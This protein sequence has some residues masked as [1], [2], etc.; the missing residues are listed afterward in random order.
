MLCSERSSSLEN[1][2]ERFSFALMSISRYWHKI[3]SDEMENFGLKGP[4]AIYLVAIERYKEGITAVKLGE[5]CGKDKSD[6]SRMMSVMEKE[7]LIFREG[8]NRYRALIKLTEKGKKAASFVQEKA[9]IAVEI[10]GQDLTDEN[11]KIFYESLELITEN[12]RILSNEGIPSEE[13]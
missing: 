5:L 8:E 7:G 3:V 12:L 11:R 13:N 10:A 6:V 1:R 4:Y 2:F 9:K